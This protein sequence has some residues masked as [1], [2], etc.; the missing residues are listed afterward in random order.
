ME[1]TGQWEAALKDVLRGIGG[2]P[3]VRGPLL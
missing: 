2:G 3:G 1:R